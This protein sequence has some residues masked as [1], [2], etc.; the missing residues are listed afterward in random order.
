MRNLDPSP[1]GFR[2]SGSIRI[3]EEFHSGHRSKSARTVQAQWTEA[4]ICAFCWYLDMRGSDHPS[5]KLGRP[6][7]LRP[8][9][10][11]AHDA[12]NGRGTLPPERRSAKAQLVR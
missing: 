9:G 1:R 5:N 12:I 7:L 4:R 11:V 8:R 3:T 2:P 6:L 10:L